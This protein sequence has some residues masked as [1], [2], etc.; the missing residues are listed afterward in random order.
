[1]LVEFTFNRDTLV[2]ILIILPLQDADLINLE[3]IKRTEIFSLN[4]T[5]NVLL[6]CHTPYVLVV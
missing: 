5:E 2:G 6:I 3:L 4:H 1:M